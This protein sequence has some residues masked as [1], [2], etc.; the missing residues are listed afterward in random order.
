MIVITIAV[1]LILT[2][3]LQNGKLIV[4]NVKKI[5]YIT[6]LKYCYLLAS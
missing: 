6:M 5:H 4:L 1:V 2:A 3:D